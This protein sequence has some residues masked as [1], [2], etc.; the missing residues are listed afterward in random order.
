MV[1]KT[2]AMMVDPPAIT[3]LFH[4][5]TTSPSLNSTA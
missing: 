5:V 3:R 1:P 2:M 4:T